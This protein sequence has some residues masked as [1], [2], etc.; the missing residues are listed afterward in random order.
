MTSPELITLDVN[1]KRG[2]RIYG[3]LSRS[4]KSR[5]AALIVHPTSNFFEHYLIKELPK[6]GINI[7]AI[8]TRY[9]NN[10]AHLLFERVIEDVGA[11]VKF[12][13]NEGFETII[14][15]GNSGGASTV[16]LYQAESEELTITKT[17]AGD[18]VW[19]TAEHLPPAD[20]IALFGAHPGRALLLS[21]WIDASVTNENDPL[22][23]NSELDI[24][25]TMNGPPFNASF[26]SK[27]R[28]AQLD[29]TNFITNQTKKR[30]E[31]LK[32]R[33]TVV[34][35][36][37]FLV[38]R[39]CADPRFLDLTL[40]PNDRETGMVWGDPYQLNYGAR[41]AA[42]FTTLKSW[43]SQWSLSSN[44]NGPKCLLRTSVPIINF[45]FTA[46]TNA[47]PSDIKM[48]SE[49]AGKREKFHQ[50]IGGTHF[51]INQPSKRAELGELISDWAKKI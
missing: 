48:W 43:M 23:K 46:D 34:N 22:S 3:L 40:D 28:K 29:R 12:L 20:G 27:Y 47:L 31:T 45:E 8:N 7:L 51:L 15:L 37:P 1:P 17:P 11:G 50:I 36:E 24:F 6:R 18:Q 44:A 33:S 42:R 21:H 38:F 30:I 4:L 10:D 2:P 13:R 9:L 5:V 19:L 32:T 39:T 25:N 26:V 14:L 35:D 41:D 49:A 16:A